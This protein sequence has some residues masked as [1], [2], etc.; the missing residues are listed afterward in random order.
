M[1]KIH[2]KAFQL[3]AELFALVGKFKD[4]HLEASSIDLP[5]DEAAA[6]SATKE[7]CEIDSVACQLAAIHNELP[8]VFV[9]AAAEY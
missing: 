5:D 7:V 4:L 1:K 3:R 9:A 2:L 8:F 6:L